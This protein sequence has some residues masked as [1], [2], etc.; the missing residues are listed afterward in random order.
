M[1]RFKET[2]NPPVPQRPGGSLF[3]GLLIGTAIISMAT[4]AVVL[5]VGAALTG[6]PLKRD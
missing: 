2:N 6:V 4:Q 5:G 3:A 1:P